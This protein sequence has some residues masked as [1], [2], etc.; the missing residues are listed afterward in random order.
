MNAYEWKQEQRR[1]RLEKAARR[2]S[3]EGEASLQSAHREVEGIPFG[4]PILVG[5]HSEKRHRRALA[6]HDSKMRRGFERLK[7]A[8][9]LARR[10]AA[11]GTAGISSDDP[12]AVSKLGDKVSELEAQRDRMKAIN[13]A[14]RKA[15]GAQGWSNGLNLTTA[16]AKDITQ[17]AGLGYPWNAQPYPSYS[18][19]NIGARIRQAKQRAQ[20]IEQRPTEAVHETV[21]GVE[22]VTDPDDNRIVLTYPRRLSRDEYKDVRRAGFVWS[23]TRNGFTRMLGT[24]G[25][26]YWARELAGRFTP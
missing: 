24:G 16:E 7:E 8:E 22:I 3:R 18:L 13:A 20:Q 21:N 19:T 12:E 10:A 25:V 26:L 2:A 9:D 15:K 14:Y 23:P 11:V 6:R 4:Q 1:E 5:H 17:R